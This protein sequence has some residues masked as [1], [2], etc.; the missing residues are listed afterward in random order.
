MS[1]N[2]HASPSLSHQ[3]LTL[4]ETLMTVA[5][6]SI[7]IA[8]TLPSLGT[9]YD[10]YRTRQEQ[11]I[12]LEIYDALLRFAKDYNALPADG[13]SNPMCGSGNQ[14]W[15][16]CLTHE[17]DYSVEQIRFDIWGEE[18]HYVATTRT[19]TVVGEA[20]TVHY[21]SVHSKG[22]DQRAAAATGIGV[23]GSNY[24]G[25]GSSAWWANMAGSTA[26]TTFETLTPAGDDVLIKVTDNVVKG[27]KLKE[28]QERLNAI[29]Q[30]LY[31]FEQVH[32]ITDLQSGMASVA[33]AVD[34]RVHYPV[35]YQSVAVDNVGTT[36]GT[37]L[38][39]TTNS[40]FSGGRRIENRDGNNTDKRNRRNDMVALMRMIGLPDAYCCSE[41]D[42]EENAVN[43]RDYTQRQPFF[44]YANPKNLINGVCSPTRATQIPFAPA[45][46][47]R[48]QRLASGNAICD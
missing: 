46:I 25:I 14:F 33:N 19:K 47:Q 26:L 38:M 28:T 35:A 39:N 21:A 8:V 3:G 41:I 31:D 2:M 34:S 30:A 40:V 20:F 48:N 29:N 16:N 4:A 32:Y 13:S 12:Q 22:P 9:V 42:I 17:L 18:R 43:P 1:V 10:R 27:A 23:S 37:A 11:Q 36:Y 7:L 45:I 44:Y 15:Y 24:A 6:V 5:V